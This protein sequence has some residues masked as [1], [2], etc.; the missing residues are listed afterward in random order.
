M[1]RAIK[2]RLYPNK[3]QEIV[4]NQH[5]GSYRFV[6]NNLLALKTNTYNENKTNLGLN[7]LSK[8]YHNVMLK[9]ENLLWLKE[10]NTKVMK[11]AIR[12]LITAYNNFFNNGKGFPKFKSKKDN[13]LSCLFPLECISSKNTFEKKN[14][15]LIKSLKNINFRCSEL[16]HNR[17]KTYKDK[18]K[19]A[20]LSKTKSGNYFLSILIDIP[21]SELIKFKHTNHNVGI[22]LGIKDFVITSD[23]E[24]FENKHFHKTEEKKIVKLQRQLSKKQKG[25]R[26]KDKLRKRLAKVYEKMNNKKEN[27]LHSVVNSLLTDYD[28]IFIEN[29]NVNG[30]LKNHCLSK[31][32]QEL[33]LFSFK[34][35]L[36]DKSLINDKRVIEVD[37]WFPSSKICH[38]CG[39]KYSD[40]KLSDREWTCVHCGSHHD[41]DLNASLN[42]LHEG[43]R[44][45]GIRSAEFTLVDNPLM[46]DKAEQALPLKSHDWLK[47]EDETDIKLVTY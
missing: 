42:I 19:S 18:I 27:Y 5:L 30:M 11:Q 21:Q 8:H 35:I 1:L 15:T 39:Y 28:I 20:T 43:E 46:D 40:L 3:K 32:I 9:D 45:I 47:Q 29:L 13:K 38:V 34:C 24:T 31:S 10:Q 22:D 6:Y 41:R 44:H 7:E 25:S 37:R 16:Y 26:N 2:I 12:Q 17:L 33:S 23:G 36:K 4:M 14:I